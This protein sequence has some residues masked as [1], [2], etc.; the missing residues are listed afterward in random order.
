M[1]FFR[2]WIARVAAVL[3]RRPSDVDDELAFHREMAEARWRASGENP[4]EAHRLAALELGGATQ[5][6]EAYEDQRRIPFLDALG[7]DLRY[8]WS[9]LRRAPGFAAAAV[10][11][12]AIGIGA[13][14]AI[15]SVVDAVLLKP[16]PYP[17][18]ERLV[19][20]GDRTAEGLA[21]NVDF[22]TLADWRARSRSFE[23]LALMRSWQPTLV[24]EGEA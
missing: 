6:R 14:T 19:T 2:E 7:Q 24:V 9:M 16:L 5:I 18:A 1:T 8:G 21:T 10:L 20:V 23:H 4:V 17:D 12:L 15:F 3:G 13:N 22:T 11:T